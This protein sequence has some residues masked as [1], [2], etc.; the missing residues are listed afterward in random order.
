MAKSSLPTYT[1]AQ[2][3]FSFKRKCQLGGGDAHL[4]FQHLVGQGQSDLWEEFQ[5][6]RGYT[7]KLYFI[8]K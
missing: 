2:P 8:N 1:S 6:N 3:L 4:S 7:E 5:D